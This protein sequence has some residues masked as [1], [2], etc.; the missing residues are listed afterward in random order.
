MTSFHHGIRSQN[1]ESGVRP[2]FVRS[3]SVIGIVGTAG[4]GT[5]DQP[6]LVTS[7]VD[8][9]EKF[10]V[11]TDDGFTLPGYLEDIYSQ[12]DATVVAINVADPTSVDA[13][14]SE[15]ISFGARNTANLANGYVSSVLIGSAIKATIQFNASETITLPAGITSVDAVKSEDGNTTFTGGGTDYSVT[16]NVITRETAGAIAAGAK[17]IVEYTATLAENT[18]FTVDA[19]TGTITRLV[20]GNIVSFS[21]VTV[22][23]YNK[24]SSTVLEADIL[25]GIDGGGT[26][27]GLEALLDANETLQ[28]K[29]KLIAAPDYSYQPVLG[30]QNA[31]LAKLNELAEKLGAIAITNTPNSTKEE[32]VSFAADH[33]SDRIFA[34]KAWERVTVDGVSTVKPTAAR[35]AGLFAR[36]DEENSVASSPS[37]KIIRGLQAIDKPDN[38][39]LV[40]FDGDGSAS[41]V[42]FLN[43]NGVATIINENGFRLYG[44]FTTSSESAQTRFVNVKRTVDF[45]NTGVAEAQLWAIDRNI[46]NDFLDLVTERII[47]FLKQ[48]EAADIL[49]K[50]SSDAYVD[51]AL[52]TPTELLAGR[53]YINMCYAVASPAQTITIRTKV[54]NG[55]V[56]EVQEV[57]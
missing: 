21:T 10:G 5:F 51:P 7:L 32:A 29:P 23:S 25:G 40:I 48:Q 49:L 37:N 46:T 15:E 56:A 50:G 17:V 42:N 1:L 33:A 28:V 57:N 9:V 27:T 44:N 47:D 54:V 38:F 22:T 16:A 6:V 39:N 31:V 35:V 52:N 24:V 55:Y 36:N 12:L 30:G 4:K 2:F 26:R 34:V 3:P 14:L 43:E 45:I 18:D 53:V 13:V 19:E 41:D 11:S 8:A 20:T